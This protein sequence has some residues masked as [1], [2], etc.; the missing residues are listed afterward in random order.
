MDVT[1]V[2]S[3]IADGQLDGQLDDIVLAV[4]DRARTGATSFYWR[5]RAD[6][7]EWTQE[8]VTLGELKFAEPHCKVSDPRTGLRRAQIHEIDPRT[9][10]EHLV[11]LLTAHFL[12]VDGLPL[13][14]A[15]K[16]AEHYPASALA[17]MVG[18]YEVVNPPKDAEASTASTT[19]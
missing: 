18:E 9:S 13:A 7:D 16:K 15:L 3:A 2:V 5:I 11:A 8:T 12:K 6:G 10:A 1:D 14:D 4:V 19:S 17:E